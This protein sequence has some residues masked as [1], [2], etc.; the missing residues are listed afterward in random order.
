MSEQKTPE[1]VEPEDTDSIEETEIEDPKAVL[2]LNAKY[3]RENKALRDRAK[4]AESELEELRKQS[5]SEQER[6]IEEAKAQVRHEVE[7]EYS[8]RLLAATVRSR[9][10][11]VLA[12]PDDAWRLVDFGDIDPDDEKEIDALIAKLLEVK[13]YLAEKQKAKT[14]ID[15]GPQGD[16]PVSSDGNAWLRSALNRR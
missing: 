14:N 15:Q 6:A 3:R 13:P 16:F 11:G 1:P 2:A 12:D 10:A 8:K 9:A 5:M 7:S 4:S